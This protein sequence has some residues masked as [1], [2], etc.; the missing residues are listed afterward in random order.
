[1]ECLDSC[2][3]RTQSNPIQIFSQLLNLGLTLFYYFHLK[4][5]PSLHSAIYNNIFLLIRCSLD[6][7]HTQV[8][9]P[10]CSSEIY[11]S[12][13]LKRGQNLGFFI[14]RFSIV[15]PVRQT[16]KRTFDQRY[17]KPEMTQES[18][19]IRYLLAERLIW[20]NNKEILFP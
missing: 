8:F 19:T 15:F 2:L 20:K 11:K 10:Y 16:G 17:G 1:M 5:F 14:L 3:G 7:L 12:K 9:Y 4:Y 13:Y 18:N 6:V